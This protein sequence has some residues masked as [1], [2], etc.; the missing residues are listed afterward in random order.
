MTENVFEL[1][2]LTVKFPL[3][4]GT[5][6]AVNHV[7]LDIPRGSIMA[8]VGESGSGKSTIASAMLRMVSNPGVIEAD[9]EVN[10]GGQNI[11]KLDDK[12][13]RKYR[14]SEVS[15]VFQAA[16]SCLNPVYT[17]GEQIIETYRE[18]G[19]TRSEQALQEE[20]HQYLSYV[21]L[22]G[23]RVMRSYPHELSGGMKQR[24]MIAFSLLLKPK[25]IILDEPTTALDVITQDYIFEILKRIHEELG[26]TLILLTHDIAVVAK[27]ATR[28]AVMYAGTVVEQGD[29]F[30]IFRSPAHEY[31]R[32][33][34]ASAPSLFD[35]VADRYS[36]TG[37]PPDLLKLP[38]GCYFSPRCA[39]CDDQCLVER[40]P[41]E[42]FG[43]NRCVSCFRWRE[44]IEK[45][46][47]GD[48]DE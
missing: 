16:Q 7:D 48:E 33:L 10:Y 31:T 14:W 8:L 34:I 30:D 36:I 3:Y 29:I 46:G 12:A 22:D 38:E 42:S 4:I 39:L 45:G 20:A 47:R 1:R 2:N 32:Q 41:S 17:V 28:M 35:D 37:S 5:I 13:I 11:L 18:H 25:V 9:S 27:V 24:V 6:Y 43:D 19:D 26:V 23:E 15:M 40:P 21:R 44:V